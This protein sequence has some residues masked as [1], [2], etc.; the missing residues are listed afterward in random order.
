MGA[1]H[2]K[3]CKNADNI[4]ANVHNDPS[5]DH[6]PSSSG[7]QIDDDEA[8]WYLPSRKYQAKHIDSLILQTLK[9]IGKIGI[10]K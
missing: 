8:D 4:S 6:R 1:C 5:L 3:C 2:W 10:E 7:I 9:V